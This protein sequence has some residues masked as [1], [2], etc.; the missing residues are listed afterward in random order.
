[1]LKQ[2]EEFQKEAKKLGRNSNSIEELKMWIK[3]AIT[4]FTPYALSFYAHTEAAK[5]S[6]EGT[7]VEVAVNKRAD[8]SVYLFLVVVEDRRYRTSVSFD[9]I[10]EARENGWEI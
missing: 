9:S 1:M 7:E 5:T 2:I 4:I 3:A 6:P 10:D 8:G